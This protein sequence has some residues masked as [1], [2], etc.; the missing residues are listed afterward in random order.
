[1]R[2]E[3][4]LSKQSSREPADSAVLV[5][6]PIS[7]TDVSMLSPYNPSHE[8]SPAPKR[9]RLYPLSSGNEESG[10]KISTL[11]CTVKKSTPVD[12]SGDEIAPSLEGMKSTFT[13]VDTDDLTLR[14]S[15]RDPLLN[16]DG[17]RA[18][19]RLRLEPS[20]VGKESNDSFPQHN[21]SSSYSAA[22]SVDRKTVLTDSG[23][24]DIILVCD[25]AVRKVDSNVKLEMT[26]VDGQNRELM[27]QLLQFFKNRL[28]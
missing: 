6:S 23:A 19:K 8:N 7:D 24:E 22:G 15:L 21:D 4:Q 28:V 12:D 2:A 5:Q 13:S 1:M 16:G 10:D 17:S 20:V 9:T 25:V 27:H 26:W 18:A 14:N 3:Q 11:S